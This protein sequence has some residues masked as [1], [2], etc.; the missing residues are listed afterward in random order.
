MKKEAA[1][2]AETL[3]IFTS[4]HRRDTPDY[5]S[6]RNFEVYCVGF[7]PRRIRCQCEMHIFWTLWI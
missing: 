5:Y 7:S 2:S 3:N 4:Q 1:C 6:I